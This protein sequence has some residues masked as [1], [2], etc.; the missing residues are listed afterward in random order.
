MALSNEDHKDV[1][2][3][4][5]KALASKVKKVTNDSWVDKLDKSKYDASTLARW[6]ADEARAKKQTA[7]IKKHGMS[8]VPDTSPRGHAYWNKQK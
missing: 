4:L 3:A 5:G 2:N 8:D 1:K 7:S 6:R